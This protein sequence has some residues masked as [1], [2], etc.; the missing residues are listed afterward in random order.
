MAEV[1]ISYA[2]ANEDVAKRVANGLKASGF[3]AWWDEQLPAHRAYSDIIEQRLRSA[4]AVVVL[5][6]KDAAQ[7]QWVRAEADFARNEKK[8]VQAQLDDTLPPLPFNQI[9]CADLRGWRGNRR[10]HGWAKLVDSVSAVSSGVPPK[11]ADASPAGS[12]MRMDRR[13]VLAGIAV[14]ML[15]VV[16]AFLFLPRMFGPGTD[17]PPRVAVLPFKNAGGSDEGLVVGMWE[18]TRHALSR[19]PQL[20][21]L[22]PNTSEEIARMGSSAARK[23]ADYLVEASVRTATDRVRISTSL[24]RSKDGAQI[25]SQTFDRKLDDVFALQTEIAQEIEGRIRGRLAKGGGIKPENFATSVEVY[26][27]YSDARATIRGRK[28]QHYGEALDKLEK[29]VAMDP[30]YAPGWATLSVAAAMATGIPDQKA[31]KSQAPPPASRAVGYAR[32]A[33]ALAPNLAAGHAALG[34]AMNGRG[35]VAQ[36]ALRRAVAL[37]P[38]DIEALNWLAG[39]MDGKETRAERFKLYSRILEIEPLWWPAVL[40]KLGIMLYAGDYA[41]AEKERERL[42]KLGATVPA[43]LVGMAIENTKGDLSGAARIGIDAFNSVKPEERGLLGVELVFALLRLGYFDEAQANFSFVPPPA[44]YLW[45]NDPRGLDMIEALNMPPADFFTGG[46]MTLAASRIYLLS[47]RGARLAELYASLG[48]SPAEFRSAVGDVDLINLAPAIALALQ[49]SG[50]PDEAIGLLA[51]AEVALN[52][53][54][55]QDT[56]SSRMKV[57]YGVDYARIYAVRGQKAAAVARLG[58]AVK[59]G[60]IP[61]PP[62]FPTDIATDPALLLL[63]GQPGFEEARAAILNRVKKEREELGPFRLA[64]SA[65]AS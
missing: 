55:A 51:T 59:G 47:G 38:N 28:I 61:E 5:W 57:E 26:A 46:I 15:L 25:W 42:Q 34:F 33:I 35:P 11:D 65:G 13:T 18:D 30:N 32:R 6:S 41:A 31:G 37:D 9:Q 49:Q 64:G 44:P 20:V 43:A 23:A 39:S 50:K 8:L 21:V 56:R 24:V 12:R 45:R 7:S 58:N 4:S 62:S 19:N 53:M 17:D 60:W 2:R 52:A 16:A 22:G 36:A 27:L 10:H 29:V 40:N 14:A 1:F 63:K 48:F 3:D 54:L